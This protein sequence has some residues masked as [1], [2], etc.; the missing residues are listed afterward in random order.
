MAIIIR[1]SDRS[2][3]K[4]CRQLWDFT[5]KIRGNWE[6][7]QRYL[8]FDFGTAM[9]AG[10]EA[11]YDPETWGDLPTM[12]RNAKE[13]FRLSYASISE[14]VKVGD[15]E[16]ELNFNEAIDLGMRMLDYYFTWAPKVDNFTPLYREIEFEVP[17]PG[18][19]GLAVYQGR[20]DLIVEDEY[21]YW[22]V[23]HKTAAQF[24]STQWLALD[25]Q[26]SSYAWAIRKQ[27]GL[28]VRGV[29]Y[30][31]ARKK[32]PDLP[33]VLKNGTFSKNK[34]QDT[35]FE[36]YL[37]AIREAGQEPHWYRDFL[38]FLKQNPKEF[39]RRTQVSYSPRTLD[40]VE[41]RIQK[42]AWDMIHDPLIYPSPSPMNCNGCRFFAPCLALME[43]ADPEPILE[44]NYVRR[45]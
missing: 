30:N 8:A 7:L 36:L 13:A 42:E 17:I 12:R 33:N 21:G 15:L 2:Y 18:L 23:D 16:F 9:H 43:G 3:F 28:E 10:W 26:C 5:S 11:Y 44:E 27:L 45:A 39:C 40:I 34:Q 41:Q 24:S 22:L 25:D 29:I 14:K 20:I 4:R 1:T 19:E 35:T 37:R 32:P 31:Q 6:P 38:L